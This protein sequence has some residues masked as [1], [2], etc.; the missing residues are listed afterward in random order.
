MI[1][2][3]FST[4]LMSIQITNFYLLIP[5]NIWVFMSISFGTDGEHFEPKDYT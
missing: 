2:K 5:F 1:W 4:M 3:L